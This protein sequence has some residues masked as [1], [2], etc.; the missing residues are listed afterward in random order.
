MIPNVFISSTIKDLR[1]LRDAVRELVVDLG[2]VPVMSEYGEVG[3]INPTSAADSCYKSIEGCQLAIFIVGRR[4]GS[5]TADGISVTHT[6]F[7]T[8]QGRGLPCITFVESDVMAFR[9]VHALNRDAKLKFPDM[10]DPDGLFGFLHE[11]C[12]SPS[13]SGVLPITNAGD[14]KRLLR[15][16]IADFV[17]LRLSETQ[18]PL[19]SQ[20]QEVLAEIKTLRRET[21]ATDDQ[22]R[23]FL[24]TYRFLLEESHRP[25][26]DLLKQIYG[27][28]DEAV[29]DVY[30]A[31]TFDDVVAKN[32][33]KVVVLKSIVDIQKM[34]AEVREGKK[35][36]YSYR[37]RVIRWNP[38]KDDQDLIGH[39]LLINDTKQLFLNEDEQKSLQEMHAS[40]RERIATAQRESIQHNLRQLS[41]AL[42]Q[43]LLESGKTT[44]VLDDLV[45]HGRYIKMLSTVDGEDYS[46]LPLNLGRG[47][48][49]VVTRH[50]LSVCYP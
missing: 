26:S 11:I 9:S 7:R 6:E 5:K 20:L 22:S 28:I 19:K 25:Y 35:A 16:Q 13:Y 41:A 37:Q 8:A 31:Q 45:G 21:K 32:G 49:A 2:Y 27:E 10:D 17:G 48:W 44:A 39:S 43:Y 3:Y 29:P 1:Y 23:L 33:I 46:A 36:R 34:V 14:A 4:Y 18:N 40:L 50:G 30:S 24:W 47:S 12:S 38:D 42:D 15:S